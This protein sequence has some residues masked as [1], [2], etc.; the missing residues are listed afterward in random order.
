MLTAGVQQ[1]VVCHG[2]GGFG[3]SS[4][5]LCEKEARRLKRKIET[6]K[7]LLVASYSA[8]GILSACVAIGTFAGVDVSSLTIVAGAAWTEV[9]VHT[10]VYSR[11]AGMENK[12]KIATAMIQ[13]LS[14]LKRF[15]PDVVVQLAEKIMGSE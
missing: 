10:A 5:N 8:A 9:A 4:H 1:G 13:Q 2:R 6:S 14:R 3:C 15:E 12:L 11:K 7:L